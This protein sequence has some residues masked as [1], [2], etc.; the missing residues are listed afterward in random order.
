MI[1]SDGT[2]SSPQDFLALGREKAILVR[3][4]LSDLNR[5]SDT[6]KYIILENFFPN[7]R[8]AVLDIVTISAGYH[9]DI[10][11]F[12]LKK[13]LRNLSYGYNLPF[14]PVYDLLQRAYTYA[15]QTFSK[16]YSKIDTILQTEGLSLFELINEYSKLLLGIESNFDMYIKALAQLNAYQYV[17]SLK[18]FYNDLHAL[19]SFK[20]ILDYV[21]DD[22]SISNSL[23][24]K[25]IRSHGVAGGHFSFNEEK[26]EVTFSGYSVDFSYYLG[27][28]D[29]NAVVAQLINMSGLMK[30]YAHNESHSFEDEARQY[31]NTLFSALDVYGYNGVDDFVTFLNERNMLEGVY[32]GR[33]I[34]IYYNEIMK[35]QKLSKIDAFSRSF[36]SLTTKYLDYDFILDIPR[37]KW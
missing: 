4:A 23:R 33:L 19:S 29:C 31:F 5:T 10:Y 14:V 18:K 2:S 22:K 16:K 8:L 6:R 30:A 32:E 12:Y 15:Y 9:Y 35:S 28:F 26:N 7:D 21:A 3:V 34:Q 24:S 20:S 36:I 1:K 27:Q 37:L 13:I 25:Y 11:S 17:E